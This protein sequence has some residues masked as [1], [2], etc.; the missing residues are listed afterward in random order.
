MLAL[1]RGNFDNKFSDSQTPSSD[2]CMTTM[3]GGDNRPRS[4]IGPVQSSARGSATS[5]SSSG[6]SGVAGTGSGSCGG[7]AAKDT[8]SVDGAR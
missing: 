7:G 8:A 1:T 5:L 2:V 3:S 6:A 4:A